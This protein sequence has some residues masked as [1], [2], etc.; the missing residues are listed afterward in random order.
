MSSSCETTSSLLSN[1][2][3]FLRCRLVACMLRHNKVCSYIHTALLFTFSPIVSRAGGLEQ[4]M[5]TAAQTTLQGSL[6]IV[7][8]TCHHYITHQNPNCCVYYLV[9]C[10]RS[11]SPLSRLTRCAVLRCRYRWWR[12]HFSCH[13]YG[14][15]LA[16]GIIGIYFH[17]VYCYRLLVFTGHISFS[18]LSGS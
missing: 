1:E 17:T 12:C 14:C 5:S 3:H 18:K 8:S 10:D 15:L 6:N 13:G 4:K 16:F 11:N 9:D 2:L 7:S